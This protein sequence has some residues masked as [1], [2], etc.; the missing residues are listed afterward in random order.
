MLLFLAL[1]VV[2]A[3][4]LYGLTGA[5]LPDYDSVRNWQIVQEVATGNLTHL[6]HQGA[7]LFYL[8]FAP[9]VWLGGNFHVL[10]HVNSLLSVAAVGGL[11]TFVGREARLSTWEMAGLAL[12]IGTSVFLTFSGRDFTMNSGNLLVLAG[13]LRAYYHRL[14]APSRQTLLRAAIWLMLGIGFN[15]RFLFTVPILVAFELLAADGLLLRR[16]NAWRVIGVLIAP[17]V[18]LGLMSLVAGL[19][20]QRHW[21]AVYYGL[22]MRG[23]PNLAG[24]VGIF[25]FDLL[26]YVYFLC[27][28]ESPLVLLTL[29]VAPVL[30]RR[31]LFQQLRQPNLVR[32]LA[33]WGYCFLAGMSLLIKA[34]RGLLL[35]YG[36]FYA[37]AFLSLR[38]QVSGKGLAV[39]VL[40]AAGFN[41]YRIEREVYAYA[42]TNYPQVAAWLQNQQVDK[43]L[44]TIGQGVAPFV[45]PMPVAVITDEKQL[46]AL[47]QQGYRYVLLDSYWRVAG[48]HRFDDVRR[49]PVVA[50]WPELQLISPLLFLEHSEYTGLTY[51]Q[52]LARQQ[53]AARDSFQ[54]RLIRLD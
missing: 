22:I 38:R 28:F 4:R 25:H 41:V 8:I 6:F 27:D 5:S 37:L 1:V 15:Y 30:W 26:Y 9:F 42:P 53:A 7:P 32:Y 33:V 21:P 49:Q 31:E 23:E 45:E 34:P 39:L 10:Q 54:L 44:S 13:L 16:G 51:H 17:F 20:L 12:F 18:V 47:R 11:A 29:L 24:N 2:A 43:L 3:V 48:V 36:V 46:P 40:L 19:P 50:A 14:Q 52:T 35:A